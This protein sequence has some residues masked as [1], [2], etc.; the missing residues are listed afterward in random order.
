[1]F[2]LLSLHVPSVEASVGI[3]LAVLLCCQLVAWYIRY[4]RWVAVYA[5]LPMA[6]DRHW[7]FGHMDKH[8][9]PSEAGIKYQVS[10]TD[11]FPKL[12]AVWF[13][14]IR[15]IIVVH[16][17]DP[18][19]TL[20]RTSAHVAIKPRDQGTAY[21]LGIKWLGEGLLIANG[22]RWARNRR[23][24]TPAF[25]FEILQPYVGVFNRCTDILSEKLDKL[26]ASGTAFDAFEHIGLCSL[27]IITRCAFSYYTD[28]QIQ[29]ENHPYVQAV[30][31]LS[32][33]W[34]ARSIKVTQVFDFI[35]YNF[36]KDGKEFLKLCKFV[37]SVSEEII[38]KRRSALNLKLEDKQNDEDKKRYL[39]FLD[40]ILTAK[41]E[42]GV[43]LTDLEI[44]EE[45]DTFLFEG[46]DTTTSAISFIM[47][48]L[49]R[50]PEIQEKCQ[51]EV[52]DILEGRTSLDIEWKDLPKFEYLT[53]CIKEGIRLH[54]PVFFIQR[55]VTEDIELEGYHIPAGT[56]IAIDIF[57]LHHNRSVWGDTKDE[58]IP[59]R[60][61]P[62]NVK[63]MDPFAFL[64][65]SA[66]QRNCIGQHFAM[67]EIKV[68][69]ARLI[70]RFTFSL[71]PG[72]IMKRQLSVVMR[73]EDGIWLTVKRRK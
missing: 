40:I 57:N 16:H 41:D 10:F 51:R 9:G 26:S 33:L 65:F 3:T 68:V 5:K 45:V 28:C 15:C 55:Q 59:D 67:N 6:K 62:D 20:L 14:K 43:G 64:P 12:H 31:S 18:L 7:F 42:D 39:D 36:T 27:D 56:N 24:L 49:A 44:R 34:I 22:D 32:D 11:T 70:H 61:S 73:T 69:V 60:F 19:R 47:Y 52:D 4:A 30:R 50:N 38:K 58:F 53:Q 66:G 46:H 17:P 23:L 1:M 29:G 2:D 21:M 8:P 48:E 63:N 25:H 13:G 54:C 72:H 37:H 71:K 35:Y